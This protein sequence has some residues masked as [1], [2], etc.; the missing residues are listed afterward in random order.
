MRSWAALIAAFG[1]LLVG[2]CTP[3]SGPPTP[4]D[5]PGTSGATGVTAPPPPP[6]NP[7]GGPT[8][9]GTPSVVATDDPLQRAEPVPIDEPATSAGIVVRITAMTAITAEAKIPG[10][11]SG[12]G[13][14]V[15]V[16]LL[17]DTDESIDINSLVVNLF[18]ASQAPANPIT[19]A[20]E[21]E[22]GI[23]GPGERLTG[24]FQFTIA[25]DQRSPVTIEVSLPDRP[26]L[27]VFTGEAP[28][29]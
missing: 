24:A 18:D 10:E 1:V 2:G 15:E 20:S 12:P 28:G 27:L 21:V 4:A 5:G 17:N 14:S 7:P 16:E 22:L 23:L 8:T 19:S 3:A 9:V 6:S 29:S 11:V 25:T 13:L 26:Q